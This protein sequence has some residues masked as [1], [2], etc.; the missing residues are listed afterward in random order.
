MENIQ[1]LID[2]LEITFCGEI[3]SEQRHI[4]KDYWE[5]LE[6]GTFKFKI[7]EISGKNGISKVD[8][9]K[10]AVK[11]S[12]LISKQNFCS[13][14]NAPTP[15]IEITSR[16]NYQNKF[17]QSLDKLVCNECE[18]KKIDVVKKRQDEMNK[19]LEENKLFPIVKRYW[20]SLSIP[21]MTLLI[22][23]LQLKTNHLIFKFI[24]DNN[25]EH[26]MDDPYLK[27][28][29]RLNL[30]QID[31]KYR[32]NHPPKFEWYIELENAL[33]KELEYYGKEDRYEK[34]EPIQEEYDVILS[35]QLKKRIS[36]LLGENYPPYSQMVTLETDFLLKAG[37]QYFVGMWEVEDGFK[38]KLEPI[39]TFEL[40]LNSYV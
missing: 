2:G 20:N 23:L 26:F 40:G 21:A 29:E 35:L 10:L 27:E 1:S 8:V 32:L 7:L 4:I 22:R 12:R 36:K 15:S 31:R 16:I 9:T 3:T 33:A 37:T 11:H 28:I 24:F 38:L 25:Y 34:S 14:C 6:D 39:D 19:I 17:L 30:I 18:E 5:F 13:K